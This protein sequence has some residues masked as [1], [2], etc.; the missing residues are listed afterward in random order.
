MNQQLFAIYIV[1]MSADL[2]ILENQEIRQIQEIRYHLMNHLH[3]RRMCRN[4]R[5]MEMPP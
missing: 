5:A 1:S 4:S 2:E 3:R